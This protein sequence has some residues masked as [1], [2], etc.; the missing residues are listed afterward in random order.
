MWKPS[1]Q[2]VASD[3]NWSDSFM[4]TDSPQRI[5]SGN[6]VYSYIIYV[7]FKVFTAVT[8]KNDVFWDVSHVTPVRTDV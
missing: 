2:D 4:F 1:L 6:D 7:R 3:S 5:S 8:M